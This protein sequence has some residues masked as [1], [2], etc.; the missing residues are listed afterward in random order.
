MEV[1]MVPFELLLLAAAIAAAAAAKAIFSCTKDPESL[2]PS[3]EE[4][5]SNPVSRNGDA[6]FADCVAN[7]CGGGIGGGIGR[8]GTPKPNCPAPGNAAPKLNDFFS[9]FR[10]SV[11]RIL[12]LFGVG[13]ST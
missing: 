6:I 1:N 9:W 5:E 8:I 12:L 13:T 3:S 11:L 4:E 7:D 10:F 2:A